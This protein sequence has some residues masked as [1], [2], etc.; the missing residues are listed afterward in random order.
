[1]TTATMA[2]MS[3]RKIELPSRDVFT[4]DNLLIERERKLVYDFLYDG[5]WKFGWKSSAKTDQ[6]AFW[7]RHFAGHRNKQKQN[8]YDCAEELKQT[9]PLLFAFW[10]RLALTVFKGHT[11]YR[12]YANGHAYGV[13]G[14]LHTDSKAD[15]AY[16]AIYYPHE[17]WEPNWAGETVLFR[18]DKSDIITSVYPRPNRLLIFRGNIPHVA[19][20]VSRTCPRLRVT[21]MFKSLNGPITPEAHADD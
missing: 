10:R 19:R 3:D 11:L 2:T 21:L 14:S 18:E 8:K 16:T 9:A 5:G 20:G 1:M 15:G 12:C 13:D 4:L 17:H 7:H 6:F